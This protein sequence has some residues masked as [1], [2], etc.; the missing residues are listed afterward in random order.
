VD[1]LSTRTFD[2]PG[3]LAA[4]GIHFV[5]LDQVDA[6]ESD[7]ARAFRVA[8]VTALDQRVGFVKVGETDKGVLWRLEATPSERA[9]L[10]NVQEGTATAVTALQ[11]IVLFAALLLAIPTRASRRAARAQSRIV[12]R[13]PE[14]P[15][16][17]PRRA[18]DRL[19]DEPHDEQQ[20]HAEDEATGREHADA[21][22]RADTDQHDDAGEH[23]DDGEHADSDKGDGETVPQS[24]AAE[25]PSADMP[26]D[27]DR[28]LTTDSEEKR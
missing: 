4:H 3:E 10:N 14:E 6:E 15:M 26:D 25:E 27:S 9:P 17:L 16:V 24:D 7:A 8:A 18:D 20:L 5:L 28:E 21:N 23:A 1:L 19:D 2:A 22:E 13:S 11:L 12:G